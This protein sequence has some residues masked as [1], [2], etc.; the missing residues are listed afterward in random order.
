MIYGNATYFQV[1]FEKY[2]KFWRVHWVDRTWKYYDFTQISFLKKKF[3]LFQFLSPSLQQWYNQK[4]QLMSHLSKLYK[5]LYYKAK[6]LFISQKF[7]S[8]LEFC[9]SL[10]TYRPNPKLAAFYKLLYEFQWHIRLS[11]FLWLPSL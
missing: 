9:L 3:W 7:F 4:M 2:L 10:L 6:L 1:D 8:F 5:L 11:H